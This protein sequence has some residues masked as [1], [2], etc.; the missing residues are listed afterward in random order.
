MRFTTSSRAIIHG[1]QIK[2]IQRM[3]DF[4]YLCGRGPSVAAIM[5]S[6][7]GS[8]YSLMYGT[9][10]I[11]IPTISQRCDIE[12]LAD[13]ATIDTLLVFASARSASPIVIDAIETDR[14]ANIM[15]V[16]E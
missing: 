12:M 14:F 5:S 11:T 8:S 2:M 6:R 3:L 7:P 16:A 13:P 4:D 15:V 10:E 9:E 1:T